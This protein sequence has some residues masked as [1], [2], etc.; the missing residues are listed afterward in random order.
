TD[1][2]DFVLR[3][4][5]VE[6]LRVSSGGIV[7]LAPASPMATGQLRFSE[8]AISGTGYVGFR[9]PAT[10]SSSVV[11]TLPDGAPTAN[12]YVLSSTTGGVLS[13]VDPAAALGGA[14]LTTASLTTNA[15]TVNGTT[16]INTTGS[17]ATTIGNLADAASAVTI[18]TGSSGG[19]TLGGLP[20]GSG[21]DDV[22]LIDPTTNK[23]KRVAASTFAT[24]A[25]WSLSGNANTDPANNFLGTNNVERLRVAANGAVSIGDSNFNTATLSIR[26]ENTRGVSVVQPSTGVGTAL[27]YQSN[28][29]KLVS[30][31]RYGG[32]DSF[33]IAANGALGQIVFGGTNDLIFTPNLSI[34]SYTVDARLRV[35]PTAAQ[36]GVIVQAAASQSANLLELQDSAGTVLTSVNASGA[37]R[38]PNLALTGLATGAGTDDVLVIDGSNNVKRVAASTFATGANWSL[39]GNANT[40]PANN[41]LG[42]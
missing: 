31:N 3:T 22:L 12:G 33:F 7:T 21:S 18:N 16:A 14:N 34:G 30:W 1:S 42:T 20:T 6:R 25:N 32:D 15:L 27:Y 23:V 38:A 5:N 24:G 35:N 13:W 26:A 36:K 4:N 2:K 28:F 8:L 11:Y 39:S 9:A 10:V 17:A 40:D 41:F 37:V 19:F 29:G